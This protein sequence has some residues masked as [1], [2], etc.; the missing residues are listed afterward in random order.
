MTP[1][2]LRLLAGVLFLL[3]DPRET[4][5][6]QSAIATVDVAGVVI[7]QAANGVRDVTV[8]VTEQNRQVTRTTVSDPNGR[9]VF[10]GLT[11]GPYRLTATHP[12][13]WPLTVEA[14]TLNVGQRVEVEIKLTPSTVKEHVSV[15]GKDSVAV[16][17]RPLGSDVITR[18]RIDTLPTLRPSAIWSGLDWTAPAPVVLVPKFSIAPFVGTA[19]ASFCIFSTS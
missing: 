1:N 11:V 5:A 18:D 19:W 8:T 13:F 16:T 6:G 4:S 14:L 15:V 17:E 10:P 12:D 7:D 3:G 2:H 9:F